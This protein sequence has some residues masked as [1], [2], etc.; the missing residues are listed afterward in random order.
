MAILK[1]MATL[2]KP[3]RVLGLTGCLDDLGIINTPNMILS[4]WWFSNMFGSR[5]KF[6]PLLFFLRLNIPFLL[7]L[8]Q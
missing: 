6:G 3:V 2:T 7:I 5:W 8:I 4:N 1:K